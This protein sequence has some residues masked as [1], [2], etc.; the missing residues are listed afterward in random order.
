MHTPGAITSTSL[1]KF[2]KSANVSSTSVRHVDAAPPPGRPLKSARAETVITSSYAAGVDSDA[3]TW[4][5]P[6]ATAYVTPAATERQIA[7][8]SASPFVLPQ[9][10]SSEPEPPRLMLAASIGPALAVT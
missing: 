5:L 7:W 1:P 10:P 2:E 6:A 3:S 4:S 8:C 9:L